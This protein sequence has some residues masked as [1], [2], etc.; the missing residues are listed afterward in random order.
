MI[1]K[2]SEDVLL[3]IFRYSL[4]SSPQF[5]PTLVHICRRWR[6]IVF[7]SHQALRL[8]LFCK[9]GSPVLKALDLWPT[10]PIA[11]EYV[12]FSR[13]GARDKENILAALK[14]SDR[15][16]SIHLTVTK[17]LLKKIASIGGQ[18]S[19]LEELVLLSPVGRRL[20]LPSIFRSGP[21]LRQL[22][23][24][25]F[26]FS[27]PLRP[28]SSSRNLVDIQLHDI[29][30]DIFL[31]PDAL[32][33]AL[34]GMAHLQTLSLRF[35]FTANHTTIPPLSKKCIVKRVD[36]PHLSCLKY[37]GT[38]EYLDRLLAGLDAPRLAD[39]EIKIELT[40]VSKTKHNVSN[41]SGFIR[42]TEKWNLDCQADIR[43]YL[44]NLSFHVPYV[45]RA[46]H[47]IR[48]TITLHS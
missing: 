14:Q 13:Y 46:S 38:S 4:G 17:S 40:Y 24:T 8:R 27:V 20:T 39:I 7:A 5:W 47:V 19:K 41:L 3:R 16:S 21:R 29:P 11:V 12:G 18:F 6:H 43:F 2:L 9:R 34:S 1:V 31:S 36:T 45:T 42:R 30:D 23:L 33:A 25:G 35:P 37:R 48:P 10:L 28:L 26:S 44:L 22:H 15:V 32:A